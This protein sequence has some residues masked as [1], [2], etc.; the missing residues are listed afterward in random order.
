MERIV[1]RVHHPGLEDELLRAAL[2]AFY[3]LR[4]I[5]GLVKRPSTSE[6]VDWVQALVLAGITPERVVAEMP[7]LGALIEEPVGPGG[8]PP[9]PGRAGPQDGRSLMFEVLPTVFAYEGVPVGPDEWLGLQGA[10]EPGLADSSLGGLYALARAVL[11]K[12]ERHYDAYDAAFARYFGA[13]E[14]VPPEIADRIWDR[15]ARDTGAPSSWTTRPADAGRRPSAGWTWA[16]FAGASRSGW[17]ISPRPTTAATATSAP[18]AR[19]RSDTRGSTPAGSGWAATDG[20][21]ARS[22]WR[23]QWTPLRPA[24]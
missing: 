4:E 1:G 10:L 20:C 14:S 23:P 24:G 22:R 17:R 6:L 12:S 3:A 21:E 9:R 5:D 16:S 13:L 11:V 18:V 8:D 15:L 7:V 2:V 19:R